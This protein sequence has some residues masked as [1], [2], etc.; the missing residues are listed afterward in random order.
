MTPA[1]ISVPLASDFSLKAKAAVDDDTWFTFSPKVPLPKA[2]VETTPNQPGARLQDRNKDMGPEKTSTEID[3][4]PILMRTP[5]GDGFWAVL[6][7]CVERDFDAVQSRFSDLE[8]RLISD[9]RDKSPQQLGE[10]VAE[11]VKDEKE[12]LMEQ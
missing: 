9:Y 4:K 8:G 7:L 6:A 11:A 1:I 12:E 10:L 5:I 3:R 2:R